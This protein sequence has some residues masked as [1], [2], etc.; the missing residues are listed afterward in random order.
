MFPKERRHPN[1]ASRGGV[2]GEMLGGGMLLRLVL[3]S[4]RLIVAPPT[5]CSLW[6]AA[7]STSY[8]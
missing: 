8:Y 1:P 3:G 5:C 6:G 7:V 2:G 4:G